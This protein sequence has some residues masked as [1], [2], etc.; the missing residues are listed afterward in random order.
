MMKAVNTIR[1]QKGRADEVIPRFEKLKSVQNS[2]GF[3]GLEVWKDLGDKEH[4]EI[5]VCTTWE[6]AKDFEAWTNGDAFKKGHAKR[7]EKKSDSGSE[8]NPVI[9]AELTTFDVVVKHGE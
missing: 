2:P 5:K 7:A 8:D 1:I 9:G 3:I 4:D 6:S